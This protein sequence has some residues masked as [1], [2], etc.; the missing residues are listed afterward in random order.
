MELENLS[1]TLFINKNM[2]KHVIS[3]TDFINESDDSNK[4]F[5]DA[6]AAIIR[7]YMS[8]DKLISFSENDASLYLDYYLDYLE[9][10]QS[11][12]A[13]WLDKDKEIYLS[14]GE[15]MLGDRVTVSILGRVDD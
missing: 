12:V 15:S 4:R 2:K 1:L 14:A 10:E 5:S 8:G 3:F 6:D 9:N 13:Y 11:I 7:K